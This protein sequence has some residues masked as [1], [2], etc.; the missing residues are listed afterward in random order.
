MSGLP[1]NS[2]MA[3]DARAAL[4]LGEGQ[5]LGLG[6]RRMRNERAIRCD[7]AEA[8]DLTLRQKHPIEWIVRFR[9]GVDRRKGICS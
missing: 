5:R 8:V 7:E 1:P 3:P 2:L 6:S 4:V 9:L